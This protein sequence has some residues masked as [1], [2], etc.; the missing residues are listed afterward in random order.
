[1]LLVSAD[2]TSNL[3]PQEILNYVNEQMVKFQNGE[4]TA[5]HKNKGEI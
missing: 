4:L 3:V 1:M 5:Q 2:T